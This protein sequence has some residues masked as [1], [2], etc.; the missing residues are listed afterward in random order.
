MPK[1]PA[2]RRLSGGSGVFLAILGYIARPCLKN[3]PESSDLSVL[4]QAGKLTV[5]Y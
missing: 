3:K 1:I 4:L 2:L 5:V